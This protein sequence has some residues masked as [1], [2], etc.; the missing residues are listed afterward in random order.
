MTLA[1]YLCDIQ[2]TKDG[3]QQCQRWPFMNYDVKTQI[4]VQRQT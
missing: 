1:I 3:M 2:D 4:L